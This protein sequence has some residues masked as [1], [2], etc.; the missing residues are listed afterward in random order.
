M[1]S[2]PILPFQNL[3][4]Q[5]YHI[6]LLYIKHLNF[7]F[8]IQYIK[9]IYLYNKIYLC[10][11]VCV[12][13]SLSLITSITTMKTQNP[14][15]IYQKKKKKKTQHRNSSRTQTNPAQKLNQPSRTKPPT[16][17]TKISNHHPPSHHQQHHH[18]LIHHQQH[19]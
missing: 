14:N 12:S 7:Y 11:C 4:Y 1:S 5:L 17:P 10:V 16:Y 3:L 9:I 19:N 18:P 8:L 15:T 6:I 2:Y 13:L